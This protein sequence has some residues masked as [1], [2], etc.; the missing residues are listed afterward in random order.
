MCVI[1]NEK[2]NTNDNGANVTEAPETPITEEFLDLYL[3]GL[4]T[5]QLNTHTLSTEMYFSTAQYLETA[6]SKGFGSDLDD[7]SRIELHEK[8]RQNV[9]HFSAA[10]QYTQNREILSGLESFVAPLE[11]MSFEEFEGTA[12]DILE[13]YNRDWLR[14]EWRTAVA[15]S[16]SARDWNQLINDDT[17]QFIEYLTQ[18]D[19]LVRKG[20]RKLHRMV[21]PKSHPIWNTMF[22]PNGWN[23]RCFTVNHDEDTKQKSVDNVPQ[24]GTNDFPSAFKTN[25]GKKGVVY[26]S[27]H[28]YFRVAQGDKVFR[29][30][31]YGLPII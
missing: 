20:H 6:L 28:P 26:P 12:K 8:L 3:L 11:Q 5:G 22:P 25:P 16:Q 2:V 27:G 15:N 31:N 19:D 18:K 24:F 7:I 10:K 17:I 1:V 29:E 9:Y 30:I 21:Y 13:R 14:T 4:F 23:C